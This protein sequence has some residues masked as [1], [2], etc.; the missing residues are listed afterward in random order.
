MF[1]K[2]TNDIP[3]IGLSGEDESEKIREEL[4]IVLD[5]R[6]D[7]IAKRC[8]LKNELRLVLKERMCE[9]PNRTYL[10]LHL[11]LD[12]VGSRRSNEK[13]ERG[14]LKIVATL[15]NNIEQSYE[16]I[17]ES[18][19]DP[20]KAK[21]ILQPLVS[22]RR[23][24]SLEELDVALEVNAD[25]KSCRDLNL[26]HEDR[27]KSIRGIYGLFIIIVKSRV[28]L[29]HKTAKE[30]PVQKNAEILG[31]RTCKQLLSLRECHRFMFEK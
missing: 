21:E 17:L 20:D 1:A 18:S 3:T 24:L 28:L 31:S 23:P 5:A 8:R 11:T 19:S 25:T 2:L 29:I 10:W 30:F 26:Q 13:T 14:P 27:K 4:E 15:P 12:E 9:V 22:T 16:R 7:D 6:V